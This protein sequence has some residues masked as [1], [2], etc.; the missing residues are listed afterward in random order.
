MK[1]ELDFL[2][3]LGMVKNWERRL[4]YLVCISFIFILLF[5]KEHLM[6]PSL[7]S[8]WLRM[9]LNFDLLVST[10]WV[11]RSRPVSSF[12]RG[13]YI[14]VTDDVIRG[15]GWLDLGLRITC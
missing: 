13:G 7:A 1:V 11:L 8:N 14:R 6:Y 2:A 9:I 5:L 3:A 4:F 15:E 12:S 10:S